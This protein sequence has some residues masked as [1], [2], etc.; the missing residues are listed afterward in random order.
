MNGVPVDLI[1]ANVST[2][3]VLYWTTVGDYF[4]GNSLVSIRSV[5]W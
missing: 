1:S 5:L 4:N 2:G 3:D